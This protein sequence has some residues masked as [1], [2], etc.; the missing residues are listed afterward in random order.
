MRLASLPRTV[1]TA[2][3]AVAA[4]AAATSGAFVVGASAAAA[5][6]RGSAATGCTDTWVGGGAKVLWNVAQNWSTG[7]VPGPTSDVCIS[8]FV[9]VTANGPVSIHS[10]H[11]GSEATV[12][13]AGTSGNPSQVKIATTLDNLG[14]VELDHS[15]LT[16]AQVDNP[17]GLEG[18]GTS[19]LTSPALHSSGDVT[20]LSGSLTLPDSFAQLSNGTL[21]G[22]SWFAAVNGVLRLPGNITSLAS[23]LVSLGTGSAIHDR[24]G[25]NALAGLT[26]VGSQATLAVGGGSL[27]LSGSLVSDGAL[28]IGSYAGAGNLSVAGTLTGQHGTIAMAPQSTVKATTVR[29]DHGS[30]LQAGGTVEGN[31]VNDGSVAPA[32]HLAVTGS[33][34][35][36]ADGT[37][38]AGIVPE[39]Q[40]AGKATLAGALI[41]GG[42]PPPEPGTRGTAITFGS[43]SGGFTSHN[44]GFNLVTLAHQ[45]D[46]VAQPQIAASP[47]SVPPGASVTVTGGDFGYGTTVTVF[48]GQVNGRVLGTAQ[49]GIQGTFTVNATIPWLPPGTYKI[50]AVGSDGRKAQTTIAVS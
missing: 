48:L 31:L 20:A 21:T 30:S 49:P 42:F 32:S 33:Y 3:L 1:L 46:V 22:G 28:D 27:A 45:I 19:V 13:F 38:I 47:S 10:L 12:I 35:Q 17:G 44:L 29:I 36:A 9:F 16:A 15:S 5:G 39:L 37:L 50:I 2:L 41:A 18:Q 14:N 24:A 43:L 4:V 23:G 7:K 25:N 6:V 34:T 40:V 26:S 8:A 11:L